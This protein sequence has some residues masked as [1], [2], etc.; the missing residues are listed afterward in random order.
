METITRQRIK[1]KIST[2]LI[3]EN[4]LRSPIVP[5]ID[6]NLVPKLAFSSFVILSYVGVAK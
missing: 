3:I 4:P 5:P 6:D 2:R 1:Y